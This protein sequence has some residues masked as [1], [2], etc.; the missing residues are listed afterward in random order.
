MTLPPPNPPGG[1]N[2]PPAERD[3]GADS[4]MAAT[5]PSPLAKKMRSVLQRIRSQEPSSAL[6]RMAERQEEPEVPKAEAP[7][8]ASAPA[9]AADAAVA[10]AGW[11]PLAANLNGLQPAPEVLSPP[12]PL[13]PH[14]DDLEEASHEDLSERPV[15]LPLPHIPTGWQKKEGEAV[16]QMSA[17]LGRRL[18]ERRVS[19]AEKPPRARRMSERRLSKAEE[20]RLSFLQ[21]RAAA[22]AAPAPKPSE[23]LASNRLAGMVLELQVQKPPPGRRASMR[24][25]E[26]VK[27]N[28]WQMSEDLP[29]PMASPRAAPVGKTELG[30]KWKQLNKRI[31]DAKESKEAVPEGARRNSMELQ[32]A[33]PEKAQ[34]EEA[35]PSVP[36]LAEALVK[37]FGSLGRA[38]EHWD[39]A[40]KG[41]FT[42]AQFYAGCASVRL[43]FRQISG[44]TE[45]DI[46]KRME[47]AEAEGP[48]D[49]VTREKWDKFF[50]GVLQGTQ[51]AELLT[52]DMGSEVEKRLE[53]RRKER[54]LKKVGEEP[55]PTVSVVMEVARAKA[56]FMKLRGGSSQSVG[57]GDSRDASRVDSPGSPRSLKQSNSGWWPVAEGQEGVVGPDE[58]QDLSGFFREAGEA[59]LE[60]L[61]SPLGEEGTRSAK[62]V[63]GF[64]RER[65]GSA[66]D[67]ASS[68]S[69]GSPDL[70][71]SAT[72]PATLHA[73]V[74]A[75]DSGSSSSEDSEDKSEEPVRTR[76][77]AEW[78]RAIEGDDSDGDGE[79]FL[80]QGLSST[81][82]MRRVLRHGVSGRDLQE[83]SDAELQAVAEQEQLAAELRQMNASG[84]LALA[85]VFVKKIG[86]LKR[87]FRW[88]DTRRIG[89][90]AQVVW[91]TGFTLLHIDSEKLCGWKP[92]EIFRQIDIDPCDGMISM[93][94]WKSFFAEA[95]QTIAQ[96]MEQNGGSD[97]EQQ[98]RLRG[99]AMKQKAA[100]K[101][102]SRRGGYSSEDPWFL[103]MQENQARKKQEEEFRMRVREKLAA[104]MPGESFAFAR[105]WLCRMDHLTPVRR[106]YIVEEVAEKM[107]LWSLPSP[108][109]VEI[110]EMQ[111]SIEEEVR[112]EPKY[113]L[114]HVM[115]KEEALGEDGDAGSILVL[116]LRDF[117]EDVEDELHS[118]PLHGAHS[119]PSAL[120]HVQR[121]VVQILAERMGLV[122]K[123]ERIG[124][125]W[126]ITVFNVEEG[127]LDKLKQQ[128]LALRDGEGTRLAVPEVSS[129]ELHLSKVL[130]EEIGLTVNTSA[131]GA[132]EV[133]NLQEFQ[134][135]LRH[136]LL[137][138]PVGESRRIALHNKTEEQ[139]LAL[140]K[141][142]AELGLN[143]SE[144][145]VRKQREAVVENMTSQ[146]QRLREQLL[147][148]EEAGELIRMKLPPQ[149]RQQDAVF[150]MAGDF[151]FECVERLKTAEGEEV[152]FRRL[153]LEKTSVAVRRR[154]SSVNGTP[155]TPQTAERAGPER[156]GLDLEE[157]DGLSDDSESKSS[158]S[159]ELEVETPEPPKPPGED[160]LI[161]RVFQ[162][163]ASGRWHNGTALF[164]RY[165]DLKG[166]AEDLKYVTP[167][168]DTKLYRFTGM[169]EYVFEDTLQLQIDMGVRAQGLTLEWFQIF[170][171]KIILRLGMQ[172]VPVLFSLLAE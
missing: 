76:S 130:S 13:P 87:A 42:R 11:K 40:K 149:Q 139:R 137:E 47:E 146:L 44:V 163:Y 170:L 83:L 5:F 51:E 160:H 112:P 118:I 90:I 127:F 19:D 140:H 134:K 104:M 10:S 82:S 88:F 25:T 54:N 111:R 29:S 169:F 17:R 135:Q 58:S 37:Y 89:K 75:L 154:R 3:R 106:S 9:F 105:E 6:K 67:A 124:A 33:P 152:A 157:L 141:M 21:N 162:Q 48:K 114:Q 74:Q 20:R 156:S 56:A 63:R 113:S 57:S 64:F 85:Y 39:F 81:S 101:R 120:S 32:P 145:G 117:A 131:D 73:P 167:N 93:K 8:E 133:Y 128:L 153:S 96:E 116:N 53:E 125:T 77:V 95:A 55:T 110:R 107:R 155:S 132:V 166:F 49:S 70:T 72:L 65:S 46:F 122:A 34:E 18:S 102:R 171:Q 126:Q 165:G 1:P 168:V 144:E 164:L 30:S 31:K 84:R 103:E 158:Q 136:E 150:E 98:V 99:H 123:T 79:T 143:V 151:G 71:R 59:G 121:A 86:S 66:G 43:N 109:L 80:K 28:M 16:A 68:R 100:Q 148:T 159:E 69:L 97:F 142:A 36:K 129:E 7:P 14:P 50:E 108:V 12:S 23:P 161:A 119:F 115:P 4:R 62:S 91:D 52:A 22:G 2:P 92:F 78:K 60:G 15:A 147:G 45:R 38:F 27:P 61:S 41:K 24:A 138:V 172:F 26:P 35:E 94:E